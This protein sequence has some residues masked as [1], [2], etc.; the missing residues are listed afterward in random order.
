MPAVFSNLVWGPCSV[1]FGFIVQDSGFRVQGSE[2]RVQVSGL[3]AQGSGFRVKGGG[4]RVEGFVHSL[5]R[6]LGRPRRARI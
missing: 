5:P 2:F 4:C 3:R 1:F 6:H